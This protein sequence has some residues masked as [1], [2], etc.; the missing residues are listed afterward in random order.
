MADT[1]NPKFGNLATLQFTISNV[2]TAATNT[3]LALAGTPGN[4]LMVMPY[5]GSIVALTV[6]GNANVTAGTIA[7][8]VHKSSTEYAQESSLLTTLTTASGSSNIGYSSVRAGVLTFAAG[9]QIGVS[10]SSATNLAA[11]TID[12]DAV[13]WYTLNPV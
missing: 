13:L 12:F 10:V 8:N 3:D 6:K 4:T 7:F 11:T 5:A 1:F 9:E 2:D